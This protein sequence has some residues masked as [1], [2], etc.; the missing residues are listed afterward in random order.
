MIDNDLKLESISLSIN[1]HLDLIIS[2]SKKD[3][4]NLLFHWDYINEGSPDEID[5]AIK[6]F[7]I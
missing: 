4:I 1:N 5:Y 6:E 2:G 7:I 3:I